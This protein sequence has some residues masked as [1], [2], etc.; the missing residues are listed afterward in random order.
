MI[1]ALGYKLM[2]KRHGNIEIV[3]NLA[4][5]RPTNPMHFTRY[6]RAFGQFG[7]GLHQNCVFI[8]VHRNR[9]RV[10]AV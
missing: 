6:A 10:R 4:Q 7:K 3:G 1:N 5:F 9:F 2:S 8:L